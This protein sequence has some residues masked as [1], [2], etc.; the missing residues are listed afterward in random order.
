MMFSGRTHDKLDADDA[1]STKRCSISD[2]A[3]RINRARDDGLRARCKLFGGERFKARC[4]TMSRYD[5]PAVCCGCKGHVNTRN[6]HAPCEAHTHTHTHVT[7]WDAIL[8]WCLRRFLTTAF[9]PQLPGLGRTLAKVGRHLSKSG[10]SWPVPDVI[11]A[12]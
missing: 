8:G 9:G 6:M 4:Q 2:N 10:Q 12:K 11:C 1:I 5:R 7:L 3:L